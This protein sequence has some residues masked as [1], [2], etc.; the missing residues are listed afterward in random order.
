MRPIDDVRL[1]KMIIGSQWCDSIELVFEG[2]LGLNLRPAGDN[3]DSIIFSA[4]LGMKD[5]IVFFADRDV[6]SDD[7]EEGYTCNGRFA[8]FQMQRLQSVLDQSRI[9]IKISGP[10]DFI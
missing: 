1:L 2:L 5:E 6:D 3:Y 9:F 8:G 4:T 7:F 10:L